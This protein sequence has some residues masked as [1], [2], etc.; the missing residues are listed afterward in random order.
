MATQ[1]HSSPKDVTI[2][3]KFVIGL[4]ILLA[5]VLVIGYAWLQTD[6]VIA[7]PGLRILD[8]LWRLF[9]FWK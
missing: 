9:F 2:N 7:P 1:I 5:I 4:I 6:Q 3:G 8:K